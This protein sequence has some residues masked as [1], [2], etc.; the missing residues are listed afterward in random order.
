MCS[1]DV[2]WEASVLFDITTKSVRK[3]VVAPPATVG[4]GLCPQLL[5]MMSLFDFRFTALELNAL[6]RSWSGLPRVDF[7]SN[8]LRLPREACFNQEHWSYMELSASKTWL[9]RPANE[10]NCTVTFCGFHVFC[11]L[12]FID[13][14]DLDVD[15]FLFFWEGRGARRDVGS[16]G[17]S[18]RPPLSM[19]H[20]PVLTLHGPMT[21]K[22]MPRI[23]WNDIASWQT[24]KFN[25][26]TKLSTPCIDDHHFKEELNSAGELSNM[27][28][29]IVLKCL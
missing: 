5:F 17:K 26:S 18:C 28:S 10:S 8:C 25:N 4:L 21:W 7:L 24:G 23:V 2:E 16:E 6:N 1:A 11:V 15:F 12:T 14:A 19:S 29:Q 9:G 27:C 20:V 22:V 13:C 3:L